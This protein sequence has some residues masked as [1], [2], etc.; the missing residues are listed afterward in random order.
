[1]L[2]QVW[3]IFLHNCEIMFLAKAVP[4]V[5]TDK[6]PPAKFGETVVLNCSVS[7]ENQGSA[8]LDFYVSWIKDG[9]LVE[10][11]TLVYKR[12]RQTERVSYSLVVR[13]FKDGGTYVCR[14]TLRGFTQDTFEKNDSL[15][16]SS[17]LIITK[18]QYRQC[19]L[20]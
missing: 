7:Y 2:V 20:V 19:Y 13:S 6:A 15:V 11:E 3:N 5:D 12:G 17:M 16:L 1:M 8:T 14:S 18:N 10:N 9:K 4:V